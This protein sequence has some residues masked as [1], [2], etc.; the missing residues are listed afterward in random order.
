MCGIVSI[1]TSNICLEHKLIELD[2]MMERMNH[3]GPDGEGKLYINNQVLLGHRRLSVIDLEHGQQP[4]ISEDNRYSLI[5]NGEI[6]NYLELREKLM[7][8]GITFKTLSDTEVLLQMLINYGA[9]ALKELNGMYAFVLH[10][11]ENNKWITARDPFGIKPLYYYQN[12]DFLYFASEIKCFLAI[13]SCK[14][15]RH[16]PAFNQYRAFH[17]SLDD[18][19]LFEGAENGFGHAFGN[20]AEIH[21]RYVFGI[22]IMSDKAHTEEYFRKIRFT[23]KDSV[24][25]QLRS[26]VPLGSH[27]SGGK[28]SAS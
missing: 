20:G 28:Y 24:R 11:R 27:L 12:G 5:F 7:Q 23:V 15:K 13:P 6:Y 25:L 2:S 18:Q 17:M 4:M 14:A 3:R 9:N 1:H 8:K 26:D 19:S 22:Q 21:Q 10:D 16:E